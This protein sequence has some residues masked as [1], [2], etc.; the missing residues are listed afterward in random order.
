MKQIRRGVH[1]VSLNDTIARVTN[2]SAMSADASHSAEAWSGPASY[3]REK[4]AELLMATMEAEEKERQEAEEKALEVERELAACHTLEK[5]RIER[6]RREAK[7]AAAA[8]IRAMIDTDQVEAAEEARVEDR[9]KDAR[10]IEE[11]ERERALSRAAAAA[12][13]RAM[14]DADGEEPAASATPPSNACDALADDVLGDSSC[15]TPVAPDV[16]EGAARLR[17]RLYEG[18]TTADAAPVLTA[19][20]NSSASASAGSEEA[21]ER[22]GAAATAA[23]L[24]AMMHADEEAEEEAAVAPAVRAAACDGGEAAPAPEAKTHRR[25]V[26]KR[27]PK[28]KSEADEAEKRRLQRERRLKQRTIVLDD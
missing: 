22:D 4:A 16:A 18:E 19:G 9:A 6:L 20:A 27:D 12:K 10:D 21:G 7:E 15:A 11:K 28:R 1:S 14:L 8:K 25:A 26:E 2:R 23:R 3:E 17:A 5:E 24:R 13:V